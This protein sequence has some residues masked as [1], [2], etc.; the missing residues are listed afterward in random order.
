[1]TMMDDNE[2]NDGAA[3]E[4]TM[5]MDDDDKSTTTEVTENAKGSKERKCRDHL[6]V[7]KVNHRVQCQQ[8]SFAETAQE[9]IGH[10]MQ[11]F[12]NDLQFMDKMNA[13]IKDA[14]TDKEWR[15][16][17]FQKKIDVHEVQSTSA[18]VDIV[19]MK[20]RA[21]HSINELKNT[22]EIAEMLRKNEGLVIANHE[23]AVEE[24]DLVTVGHF[25]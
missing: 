6:M 21:R 15:N 19:A 1:M 5:Q 18:T 11:E 22:L 8:Q 25:F 16:K 24:C 14:N 17:E 10:G 9:L 12:G 4:A 23:G 20:M 13:R 7:V 3:G 2:N